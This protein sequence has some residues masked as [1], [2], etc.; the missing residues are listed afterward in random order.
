MT[1]KTVMADTNDLKD[2]EKMFLICNQCLWNVTCVNKLHLQ[3]LIGTNFLC[4]VC[5]QDQMSSFPLKPNDSFKFTY[6]NEA[7]L[8]LNLGIENK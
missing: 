7:G 4:P 1:S 8:R 2:N 5:N 3:E 6:P